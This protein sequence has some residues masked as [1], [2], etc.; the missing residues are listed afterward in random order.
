M[1]FTD[2]IAKRLLVLYLLY[3]VYWMSYYYQALFQNISLYYCP[4]EEMVST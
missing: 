3:A 4:F 1:M 2:L